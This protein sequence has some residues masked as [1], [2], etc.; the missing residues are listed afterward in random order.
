MLHGVDLMGQSHFGWR[1]M[2]LSAGRGRPQNL[3]WR[4]R[5]NCWLLFV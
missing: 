1:I 3:W 5:W 2:A 4:S